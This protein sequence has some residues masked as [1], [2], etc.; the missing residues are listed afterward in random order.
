ML[1]CLLHFCYHG[2]DIN[3]YPN[4]D[5]RKHGCHILLSHQRTDHKIL[6]SLLFDC[7]THRLFDR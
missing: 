2:I 4:E 7:T 6:Q 1:V 5:D 3:N